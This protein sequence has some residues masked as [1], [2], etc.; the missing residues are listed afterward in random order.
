MKTESK[1]EP[2]L[3]VMI[4]FTSERCS[5]IALIERFPSKEVARMRAKDLS[6]NGGYWCSVYNETHYYD[7]RTK[8]EFTLSSDESLEELD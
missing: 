4:A 6:D 1:F 8:T 3:W 2:T 5:Q 7:P